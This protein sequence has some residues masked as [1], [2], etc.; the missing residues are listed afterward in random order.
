[1]YFDIG[2]HIGEWS[3][4]NLRQQP[5]QQI[6]CVEASPRT[7]KKLVETCQKNANLVLLNYAVTYKQTD[8]TIFYHADTDTLSTLNVEWSLDPKSRFY[9][10]FTPMHVPTITLDTLIQQYGVPD[11]IKIDVEGGEFDVLMSLTRPVPLLCFEWASEMSHVFLSSV[12]YLHS[13]GYRHFYIQYGDDYTF[14]PP[15]SDYIDI[16]RVKQQFAQTVPKRDWGM[17][18]AHMILDKKN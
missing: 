3:R 17:I 14:R 5:Q 16:I 11:L 13:L 9:N 12:D 10:S 7:F 15:P 1:M 2:A 18:W 4:A 6:V 8:T